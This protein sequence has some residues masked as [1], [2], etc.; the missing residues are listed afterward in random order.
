MASSQFMKDKELNIRCTSVL[1]SSLYFHSISTDS[2]PSHRQHWSSTL[3]AIAG[4]LWYFG[5]Y[6]SYCCLVL[7][8][9]PLMDNYVVLGVIRVR[10]SQVQFQL[11]RRHYIIRTSLSAMRNLCLVTSQDDSMLCLCCL[12]VCKYYLLYVGMLLNMSFGKYDSIIICVSVPEFR[13]FLTTF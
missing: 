2:L 9:I 5:C 8:V 11:G 6:S 12:L 1:C 4:R 10:A 3:D 13:L 7:F